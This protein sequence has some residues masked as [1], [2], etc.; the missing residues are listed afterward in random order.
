VDNFGKN[1][2]N[3]SKELQEQRSW[4]VVT[5]ASDGETEY[6]KLVAKRGFNIVLIAR[7]QSKLEQ[8]AAELADFKTHCQRFLQAHF[9]RGEQDTRRK[10]AC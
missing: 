5:G 2:N 4:A 3:V 10:D 9:F 1:G 6:C 8:V 7:T